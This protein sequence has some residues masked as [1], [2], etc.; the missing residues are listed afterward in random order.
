MPGPFSIVP[1]IC[2]LGAMAKMQEPSSF[3]RS[4]SVS[5]ASDSAPASPNDCRYSRTV[6]PCLW[7]AFPCVL[8]KRNAVRS[9]DLL[10]T[11][12]RLDERFHNVQ[13][14]EHGRREN[15]RPRTLL[16]QIEGNRRVTHLR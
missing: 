4:V 8:Q 11:R 3:V 9:P 12:L 6:R 5:G 7:A 2:W 16:D 10:S 13:L 1:S 15:G 14:A